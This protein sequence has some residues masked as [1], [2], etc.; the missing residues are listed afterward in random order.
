MAE[1]GVLEEDVAAYIAE[2]PPYSDS[3][4]HERF[5]MC[6]E[7]ELDVVLDSDGNHLSLGHGD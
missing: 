3:G 2:C 5:G 6:L 4:P 7:S 1:L